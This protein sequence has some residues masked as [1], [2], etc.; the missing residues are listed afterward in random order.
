MADNRGKGDGIP[1]SVV[2][3]KPKP[4]AF[5]GSPPGHAL[6]RAATV[7]ESMSSRRESTFGAASEAS[8]PPSPLRRTSFA[9]SDANIGSGRDPN[10]NSDADAEGVRETTWDSAPL[11][12]ALLPAFGGVLVN[13]GNAFV[14][15]LLLLLL[16]A[17]FLHLGVTKPW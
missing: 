7:A 1:N 15:D 8:L 6:R 3:S 17:K 13:G 12:F 5:L 11:A 16:G 4:P 10:K 14:T 2:A 9:F